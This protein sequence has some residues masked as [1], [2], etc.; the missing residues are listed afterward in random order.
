MVVIV[1][2]FHC[3]RNAEYT[4]VLALELKLRLLENELVL[5]EVRKVSEL[6]EEMRSLSE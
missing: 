6:E 4:L 3:R 2:G 5:P 1:S